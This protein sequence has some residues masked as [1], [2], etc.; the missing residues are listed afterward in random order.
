[1]QNIVPFRRFRCGL[2]KKNRKTRDGRIAVFVV[3]MQI[4]LQKKIVLLAK[5]FQLWSNNK[6]WKKNKRTWWKLQILFFCAVDLLKKI[7]MFRFYYYDKC[8][9]TCK[10]FYKVFNFDQGTNS[11]KK[12]QMNLVK[13]WN[14]VFL[15][16]LSTEKYLEFQILLHKRKC[17]PCKKF[18]TLSRKQLW[19]KKK[20]KN[21][22]KV[23]NF[24]FLPYLSTEKYFMVYRIHKNNQIVTFYKELSKKVKNKK[25]QNKCTSPIRTRISFFFCFSLYWLLENKSSLKYTKNMK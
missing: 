9:F 7:L 6:L 10:R 16:C 5:N 14:F 3:A 21:M 18:S 23:G 15:R 19:K 8:I 22:L 1:M 24:V 17:F 2:E 25:K 4:S 13:V 12:K 20:T 11:E